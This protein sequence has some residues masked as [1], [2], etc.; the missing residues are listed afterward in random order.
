MS[1]EKDIDQRQDLVEAALQ[2]IAGLVTA[3][4]ERAFRQANAELIDL[5]W[6]IGQYLAQ[7]CR[8]AG[9]GQGTVCQLA[10]LI[11][12][13]H[14]DW[15]GFSA[16][17]LWRMKQCVEMYQGNETLAPLV[18]L[19][20]WTH[21]LLILGKC[22]TQE[23]RGF[24]LKLAAEQ[25]WGKRELERQIEGCLFERT[26]TAPPKLAPLLRDIHPAAGTVFKDSYLVEFL[27]LPEPHSEGD[28]QRGLVRHLKHFLLELGRDFCF[29]GEQFQVQVGH[30]DFSLD[31]L[32]FHRGLNCL[33]AFELKVGEFEPEHLGK[34]GF[35]LEALDRDHRKPHEAPSI[36][37]LLCKTRDH[38]VV[39]YALSRSLSPT[40]IAEYQTRLPD[41]ALLQ[42]KLDEFYELAQREE[43]PPSD[44]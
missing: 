23:E 16:S 19:L 39:E 36:G 7:Q 37:V 27:N 43:P 2:K 44:E 41:K 17:N 31:L 25:G 6:R 34:L 3:S 33:V 9:W 24:Y 5:Y 15:R 8:Q 28:L 35:Y 40:L 1:T 32:F 4:R 30:R 14:P 12:Q 11:Q 22:K 42:A 13:R 29:I 26:L 38:D 20:G 18:R 21:N 10:G